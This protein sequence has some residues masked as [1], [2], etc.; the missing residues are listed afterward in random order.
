VE[1]NKADPERRRAYV[2]AWKAANPTKDGEY[3]AA[4]RARHPA[5]RRQAVIGWERRNPDKVRAIRQ[6]RRGRVRAARGRFSSGIV[7]KFLRLQ[8]GKC[9]CCHRVLGRKYELDHIEPLARGG[10]NTDDNAQLLCPP[11]NRRKAARDPISFMQSRGRL[12]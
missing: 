8:R 3:S 9:A 12:L 2:K 5:R 7:Q 11:C 6:N 1:R 10:S 4:W